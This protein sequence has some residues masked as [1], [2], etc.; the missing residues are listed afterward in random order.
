MTGSWLTLSAAAAR[1]AAATGKWVSMDDVLELGRR[2][3]LTVVWLHE[4]WSVH[5]ESVT[6]YLDRIGAVER[7][8]PSVRGGPDIGHEA[9]DEYRRSQ[10]DYT[11]NN[12]GGDQ[13]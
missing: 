4:Y 9:E 8:R 7:K 6:A 11:P 3:E 13:Q 12:E 2:Q 1:I 10:A 5:E